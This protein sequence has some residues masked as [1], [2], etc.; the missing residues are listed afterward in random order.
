MVVLIISSMEVV[1][2]M[3][4]V[5]VVMIIVVV[6]YGS[7]YSKWPLNDMRYLAFDVDWNGTLHGHLE[8]G[9]KILI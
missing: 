9:F 7:F 6:N 8:A 3:M 5:M 2:I 1:V 4:I